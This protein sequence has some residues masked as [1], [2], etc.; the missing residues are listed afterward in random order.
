[1]KR[2]SL[3]WFV[4][5]AVTVLACTLGAM[6]QQGAVG[7]WQLIEGKYT[8]IGKNAVTEV[9]TVWRIDT[10]TGKADTYS[11]VQA[12]DNPG[13]GWMPVTDLPRGK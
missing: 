2:E 1:M 3:G 9:V 12:G 8:I 6:Q 11:S 4:A 5:G 10:V 7:R 13:V